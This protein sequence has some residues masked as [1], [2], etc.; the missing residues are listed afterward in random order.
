MLNCLFDREGVDLRR[1]L[2]YGVDRS[3]LEDSIRTSVLLKWSHHPDAND[4]CIDH[5]RTMIGIGG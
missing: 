1:L 4:L 2:R 5:S 3:I